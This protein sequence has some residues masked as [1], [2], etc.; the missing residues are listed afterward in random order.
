CFIYLMHRIKK[1]GVHFCINWREITLTTF[2]PAGTARMGNATNPEAVVDERLRV[3]NVARLRVIDASV[4]P[5][6]PNSNI[7]APCMMVGE[8]GAHMVA[9]D[10]G[11]AA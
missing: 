9:Q 1:N 8:K 7:N 6:V 5:N 10:H 2:H 3:R 11:L 4:M